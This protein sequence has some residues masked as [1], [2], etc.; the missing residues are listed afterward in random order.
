MKKIVIYDSYFG[1][2][3]AIAEAIASTLECDFVKV[4]V[5]QPKLINEY[6]VI[7]IGSP[8]RAFSSTKAIKKLVKEITSNKVKIAFFDTRLLINEETP[9]ILAKLASKFGYSN[10]SLEKIIL[11]KGLVNSI[12]SGEFFVGDNEGPLLDDEVEKARTWAKKLL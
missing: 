6:D 2:T 12:D 5:C 11:K 9:K 4:H 7:V 3:A 10:D 1:N 8:T